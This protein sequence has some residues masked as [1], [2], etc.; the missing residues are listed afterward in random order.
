MNVLRDTV[1]EFTIGLLLL[2]L[3][4]AALWAI[5]ISR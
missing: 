2:S 3:F 1:V 4:G 5:F